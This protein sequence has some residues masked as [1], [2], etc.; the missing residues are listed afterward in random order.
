M[1]KASKIL[2]VAALIAMVMALTS[3]GGLSDDL[4]GV[5]APVKVIYTLADGTEYTETINWN[6]NTFSST[7]PSQTGWNGSYAYWHCNVYDVGKSTAKLAEPMTNA[8]FAAA[9]GV[10]TLRGTVLIKIER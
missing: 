3:C 6:N 7:K 10:K 8:E 9:N 5:Y 1:K 4:T 2:F